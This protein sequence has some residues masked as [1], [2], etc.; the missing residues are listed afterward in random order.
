MNSD[1]QDFPLPRCAAI[2]D[3]GL[4]RG[5]ADALLARIACTQRRAERKVLGLV[6]IRT[7]GAV[8]CAGDMVLVDVHTLDEYLVSQPLGSGAKGCRADPQ[9]F[10]RASQ[11]LRDAALQAP[12]LVVCNRFG[13]L[14][15]EGAGFTQE[16][17]TLMAAGIPL[18][19]VVAPQHLA[20]WEHFSGGT[21]MLP[22]DIHAIEDWLEQTLC[23][24][25]SS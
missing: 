14:E 16:L 22:A 4:A 9:G 13:G 20:A 11:V 23:A 6:M 2:L 21:A 24:Q 1:L 7:E 18:L 12:D 8:G 3:E 10:A 17:L 15:A 25:E 5:Q 19:T